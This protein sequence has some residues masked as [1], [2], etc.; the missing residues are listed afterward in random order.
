VIYNPGE[1]QVTPAAIVLPRAGM[2]NTRP[3]PPRVLH[4][5][6]HEETLL[7]EYKVSTGHVLRNARAMADVACL[8][9]IR[10]SIITWEFLV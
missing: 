5:H 2:Y 4:E 3:W 9:S 7:P 1:T 8:D 10:L 6:C